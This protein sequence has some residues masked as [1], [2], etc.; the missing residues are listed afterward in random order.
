MME[1]LL[2]LKFQFGG[3]CGHFEPGAGGTL[4][5]KDDINCFSNMTIEGDRVEAGPVFFTIKRENGSIS[6]LVCNDTY[7]W[8]RLKERTT[9]EDVALPQTPLD[10]RYDRATS[11]KSV[12]AASRDELLLIEFEAFG[13]TGHFERGEK[14]TLTWKDSNNQLIAG[15]VVNGDRIEAGQNYFTIKRNRNNEISEV[16]F[17]DSFHWEAQGP[18]ELPVS[19]LSAPIPNDVFVTG[20]LCGPWCPDEAKARAYNHTAEGFVIF[21]AKSAG[22]LRMVREDTKDGRWRIVKR[23]TMG[24]PGSGLGANF[25]TAAWDKAN[26]IAPGLYDIKAVSQTSLDESLAAVLDLPPDRREQHLLALHEDL[27]DALLFA[28]P[29]E[30]LPPAFG[31]PGPLEGIYELDMGFFQPKRDRKSVV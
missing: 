30:A 2:G 1:E 25:V 28:M 20:V 6:E 10:T 13:F 26:S 11:M 17:M 18:V 24:P 27:R 3:L 14:N 8:V 16:W 19:A 4:T 15:M 12:I 23:P 21:A 22:C 7:S 31:V 9:T 29:P 5:W